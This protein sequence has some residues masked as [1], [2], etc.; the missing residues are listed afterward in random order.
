MGIVF[1][2]V[3]I[4]YGYIC[5]GVLFGD[6]GIGIFDVCCF[7]CFVEK[8]YFEFVQQYVVLGEYWWNSGI[9]IVCVLVWLK[10]IWQL[11]F[12]IYVVCEQVVVQ[13]W[14][15]GDFFCVDCDVFVVL[16]LNLI[17]YVVMELFVS[18]L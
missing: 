1:K 13:G 16:L 5:V 6:V 9:F 7:D 10:V 4:G 17:D 8:L 14:D 11:E 18:Q 12:V 3:E 15:D 2:Y